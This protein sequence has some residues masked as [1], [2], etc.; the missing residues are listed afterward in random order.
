MVNTFFILEL[1][2]RGVIIFKIC[3]SSMKEQRRTPSE[4]LW[5]LFAACFQIV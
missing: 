4:H 2:R 1:Q 5:L 3:G